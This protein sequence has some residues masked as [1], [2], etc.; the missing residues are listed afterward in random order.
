MGKYYLH[1]SRLLTLTFGVN[2]KGRHATKMNCP[3]Q[4]WHPRA[5]PLETVLLGVCV[6]G[7]GDT[8]ISTDAT[9][10]LAAA[11]ARAGIMAWV[12]GPVTGRFEGWMQGHPGQQSRVAWVA[13]LANHLHKCNG[14][15]G[16]NIHGH[17]HQGCRHN[18]ECQLAEA[19]TS[20]GCNC[21]W[22]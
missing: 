4:E 14:T 19:T 17:L 21:P 5:K 8:T 3:F 15:R 7:L 18:D 10:T 22:H 1:G 11:A 13:F 16:L 20:S 6:S 2:C 9:P 12:S